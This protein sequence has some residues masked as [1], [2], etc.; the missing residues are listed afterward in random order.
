MKIRDHIETFIILAG[1]FLVMII[2]SSLLVNRSIKTDNVVDQ[3]MK[4]ITESFKKL[5]NLNNKIIIEHEYMRKYSFH[6]VMKTLIAK[7]NEHNIPINVALSLIYIESN[8]DPFAISSTG[9]HGLFQFNLKTWERKLSID[10][11]RM[12]E[13]EY[14]IDIAMSIL[15]DCYKRAG[16]WPLALA[17]YN[18]GNNHANSKHPEKFESNIFK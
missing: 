3:S 17:I 6:Y 4:S 2:T 12:Y 9:D 5:D 10:K 1:I 14:N 11:S 15:S 13:P 8:F 18:A 7:C 16:N